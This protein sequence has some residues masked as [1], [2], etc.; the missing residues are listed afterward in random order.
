MP[1]PGPSAPKGLAITSLVTGIIGLILSGVP[2]VGLLI[3]AVAVVTGI[4][5][6]RKTQP[7]GM[8]ITGIITGGLWM[9]LSFILALSVGFLLSAADDEDRAPGT[10]ITSCPPAT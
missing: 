9:L 3:G 2:I 8:S 5:A 7:K 10:A 6:L 1:M 4:V